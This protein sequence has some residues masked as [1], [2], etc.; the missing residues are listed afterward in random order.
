[1]LLIESEHNEIIIIW[2]HVE[3][4]VMIPTKQEN[5]QIVLLLYQFDLLVITVID[6]ILLIS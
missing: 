3:C 4:G 5:S 6:L 1:M 2:E